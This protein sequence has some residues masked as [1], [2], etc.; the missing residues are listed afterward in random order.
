MGN[1]II[2][3]DKLQILPT[4]ETRLF[5]YGE[6]TK[7]MTLEKF[8]LI[9]AKNEWIFESYRRSTWIV[10][11]DVWNASI[12]EYQQMR[13]VPVLIDNERIVGMRLS[14]KDERA[15]FKFCEKHTQNR[16]AAG[17][18]SLSDDLFFD[19]VAQTPGGLFPP[20]K[21]PRV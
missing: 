14:E 12:E 7:P 18:C 15:M 16:N 8:N 3:G 13:V 4:D 5:Y 20:N 1:T 9:S 11:T 6:N 2:F 19:T 10:A 17:Y 21:K